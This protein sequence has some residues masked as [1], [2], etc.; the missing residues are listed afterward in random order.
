MPKGPLVITVPRWGGTHAWHPAILTLLYAVTMIGQSR[1]CRG[2]FSVLS[3]SVSGPFCCR[4]CCKEGILKSV[5]TWLEGS[6]LP[7]VTCSPRNGKDA[8]G[9]ISGVSPP[10]GLCAEL[11]SLAGTVYTPPFVQTEPNRPEEKVSMAGA[12]LESHCVWCEAA[13]CT[14]LCAHTACRV[15]PGRHNPPPPHQLSLLH[16]PWQP[17]KQRGLPHSAAAL[18]PFFSPFLAFPWRDALDT[19]R[20]CSLRES[21][22]KIPSVG[23]AA[24]SAEKGEQSH[25]SE[26]R[27]GCIGN[28]ISAAIPQ[29][30]I[31]IDPVCFSWKF[32]LMPG[33][34][35]CL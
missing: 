29:G 17:Q 11:W 14:F 35:F 27:V 4:D 3:I 2:Y 23:E 21:F 15:T 13:L 34:R 32:Q 12:T 16:W 30:L 33:M 26:G 18:S 5:W 25:Q 10:L 6:S 31:Q 1:L 24:K 19:Y 28:D 9:A 22:T 7:V 20:T 8:K